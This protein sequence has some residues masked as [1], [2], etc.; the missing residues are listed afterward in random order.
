PLQ[1]GAFQRRARDAT[2]I[3]AVRHEDPA[4]GL[5]ARDIGFAGLALGIERIEFLLQAFFAGL[6]GVDCAAELADDR[7]FHDGTRRFFRPKKS[8]PFQR[9]PVIARAMADS[10][11]YGRP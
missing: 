3:I 5:L 9:V 1:R 10:D 6:A 11:L 7:L 2:V 4:L 8:K